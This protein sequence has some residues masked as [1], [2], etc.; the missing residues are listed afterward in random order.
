MQLL[1]RRRAMNKLTAV[2]DGRAVHYSVA[3]AFEVENGFGQILPHPQGKLHIAL[4]RECGLG[5]L[6]LAEEAAAQY[7]LSTMNGKEHGHAITNP[8]GLVHFNPQLIDHLYQ[9]FDPETTIA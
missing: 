8:C 3:R 2:V 7:L 4:C 9:A 5:V 6:G 1:L